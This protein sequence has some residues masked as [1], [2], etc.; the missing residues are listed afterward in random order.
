M[1]KGN[2]IFIHVSSSGLSFSSH[3]LI[4]SHLDLSLCIS[5]YLIQYVFLILF[6]LFL[7]V[8]LHP[9]SIFVL[10]TCLSHLVSSFF[11]FS[12]L[13]FCIICSVFICLSSCLFLFFRSC[14]SFVSCNMA[15]PSHLICSI[16]SY[17]SHDCPFFLLLISSSRFFFLFYFY[18]SCPLLAFLFFN[19]CLILSFFLLILS[20][21]LMSLVLSLFSTCLILSGVS[22]SSI[23]FVL[24]LLLL[25][26]L[27]P[28][29]LI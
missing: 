18:V 23:L 16:L 9:V 10:V 29:F 2:F 3:F 11:S 14:L 5:Y 1:G 22:F 21:L 13:L 20:L 25:S 19:S 15:C 4:L 27:Y 26:L 8:L 24:S 17:F 7:S 12:S 28:F 6:V